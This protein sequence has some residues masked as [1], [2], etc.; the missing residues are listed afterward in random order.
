MY[1]SSSS[2]SFNYVKFLFDVHPDAI[3]TRDQ[4]G[5]LPVNP[6]I[7]SDAFLRAQLAYALKV[8][9]EQAVCTPDDNGRFPLHHAIYNSACLGAIK[10]LVK[11]SPVAFQVSDKDGILPLHIVCEFGT[12][13]VDQFL[14][15]LYDDCLDVCDVEKIFLCTIHAVVAIVTQ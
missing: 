4:A 1:N 10:L 5:N 12:V 7:T 8:K 13:G 15:E 14:A 2:E 11:G 6:A 9:D 3:D